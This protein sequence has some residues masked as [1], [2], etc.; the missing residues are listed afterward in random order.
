MDINKGIKDFLA[1]CK[2]EKNLSEKTIKAYRIDISQFELFLKERKLATKLESIDK[3]IIK[4]YLQRLSIHKPKTIKRK[5]AALKT[6]FNF[7]EYEDIIIVNPFRKIRINIKES[8]QLPRVMNLREVEN[9]L[10]ISYSI[11]NEIPNKHSYSFLESIRSIAIIE[12]LFATG[13]RV[14]ELCN[15][16]TGDIDLKSGLLKV[17]GKGN[18][19]RV[20][21]ICNKEVLNALK[22]YKN[23]F[24]EKMDSTNYFFINRIDS[25]LSEQ[26]VRNLIKRY[27]RLT[28][29]G[30]RITPH[31]FRH[32]F[33]TLLLEED[34]DIKYIQHM[35]GH[36]S[37]MTTQIYTHVNAEKQKEILRT[38]HPRKYIDPAIAV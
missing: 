18:K 19:E 4:E 35:L 6:M 3:L 30:R 13:I 14:S 26:S 8:K 36:S 33:A 10:N 37:I 1:H 23:A 32:T 11:R 24:I 25:R 34:V 5:V 20:I 31:T 21:Q 29:I 12:L 9:I 17:K 16:K 38:K 15:I 7:F 27:S 28:S 22:Y 2:Y